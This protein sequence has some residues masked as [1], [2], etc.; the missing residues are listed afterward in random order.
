MC[1]A[2][3]LE[4]FAE[5][6]QGRAIAVGWTAVHR[7]QL[8]AQSTERGQTE[9][10]GNILGCPAQSMAQ[11]RGEI[12]IRCWRGVS[13]RNPEGSS[14]PRPLGH[15]SPS[16]SAA[17]PDPPVGSSPRA[18]KTAQEAP[19]RAPARTPGTILGHVGGSGPRPRSHW[20]SWKS[21]ATQPHVAQKSGVWGSRKSTYQYS[22]G[23]EGT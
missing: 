4:H 7:A 5:S 1:P 13:W 9:W 19:E 21:H 10:S 14:T 8:V 11:Q 16:R 15:A 3:L 17:R 12:A 22:R 20:A 23:L 2:K 6:R 18:S